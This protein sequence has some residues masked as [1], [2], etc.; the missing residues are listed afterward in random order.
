[1]LGDFAMNPSS[2][3]F[4]FLTE[5][6]I[7]KLLL[8]CL[9]CASFGW[10][11]HGLQSPPLFGDFGDV[12]EHLFANYTSTDPSLIASFPSSFS[13]N[14]TGFIFHRNPH[15]GAFLGIEVTEESDALMINQDQDDGWL[16]HSFS[17]C[18]M[19]TL[20][21]QITVPESAETPIYLNLL[22]DWNHN[23]YWGDTDVCMQ[24]ETQMIAP[25][26]AIQ[27]LRLDQA[28]FQL[29]PGFSGTVQ[30][31]AFASGSTVGELWLR[32]SISDTPVHGVSGQH[33]HGHGQFNTGET[34]DYFTCTLLTNNLS[35]CPKQKA[36]P[37]SDTP[38]LSTSPSTDIDLIEF[39]QTH[40]N[41]LD[42]FWMTEFEKIEQNFSF[43]T[44]LTAY[45][46]SIQTRCGEIQPNNAFFCVW[47][48]S[49]YYD[50]NFLK[51]QYNKLGPGAA[52]IIIAH[53]W[54]HVLQSQ[55]NALGGIGIQNELQADCFAGVYAR[56]AKDIRL[57]DQTQI[58]EARLL[59]EQIGDDLPWHAPNAHGSSKQRL[60]AFEKGFESG[61]SRCIVIF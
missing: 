26:W 3:R 48:Y 12:P 7:K 42:Q 47:S 44:E 15:Q 31:P 27:N 58:N 16:P 39:V 61:M 19:T 35:N 51:N 34:E 33:W 8:I 37:L 6:Q 49:I 30:L 11:T 40:R 9:F 45:A 41:A 56:H 5:N 1:L 28:P 59:I 21:I 10:N 52:A 36:F 14:H 17:T 54:G 29:E 50:L 4:L 13:T 2:K 46:N 57:F 43:L 32:V 18:Q 23:G 22:A 55:L 38:P 53:E 24:P 60:N 25:E 20:E